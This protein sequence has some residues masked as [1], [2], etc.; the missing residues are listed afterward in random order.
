ML[1]AGRDL[2]AG[3]GDPAAKGWGGALGGRGLGTFHPPCHVLHYHMVLRPKGTSHNNKLTFTC[4]QGV[5][6]P[7]HQTESRALH[8]ARTH[9]GAGA[10]EDLRFCAAPAAAETPESRSVAL[11]SGSLYSRR[12]V[13]LKTGKRASHFFHI[14]FCFHFCSLLLAPHCGHHEA[15]TNTKSVSSITAP[16]RNELTVSQSARLEKSPSRRWR[17]R[18]TASSWT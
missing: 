14:N 1:S 7:A 10:S 4:Q 12:P 5:L 16:I 3:E 13:A 6:H 9:P 18:R 8:V 2:A 11:V 15:N 17:R